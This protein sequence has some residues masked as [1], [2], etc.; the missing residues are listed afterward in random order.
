VSAID[1]RRASRLWDG[2]AGLHPI[3]LSVEAGELVVVRGR[4]GSGKST[5]LA[6]VAGV[7]EPGSGSVVVLGGRPGLDTPWGD[8]AIVPQVLALSAELSIGENVSD[9]ARG[10]DGERVADLLRRLDVIELADR[11]ISEVSMGQQQRTAVARAMVADPKVLL[12]DEPTSY[13]DDAHTRVVVDA[14]RHAAGGGSAVLVATHDDVVATAA[15]RV[16]ELTSSG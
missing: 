5:L 4:S 7:C 12:A 2:A 1:L 3:D 8:V 6:L 11:T 9:C 15:D 10:A 14:L 13:Q 16:I